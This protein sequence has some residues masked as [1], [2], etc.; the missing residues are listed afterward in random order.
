MSGPALGLRATLAEDLAAYSERTGARR[1]WW[2]FLALPLNPALT[3]LVLMRVACWLHQRGLRAPARAVYALNVYTT[4][5]EV[6]PEAIIGPGVFIPHPNGVMLA[7]VKVGR[8]AIFGPRSGM[9]ARGGWA[10]DGMPELG[11]NVTIYVNS[12]V[13]GPIRVGDDAVIAGYSMV[14]RDVPAGSLAAGAPAKTIRSLTRDEILAQR[15]PSE[16]ER[17]VAQPVL[18]PAS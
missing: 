5:L 13:L 11:D 15:R 8:N 10:D 6:R 16:R 1:R 9:G 12:V 2:H 4:G 3:A 17:P 18:E 14:T 7:P